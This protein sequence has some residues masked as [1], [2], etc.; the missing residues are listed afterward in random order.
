M[1]HVGIYIRAEVYPYVSVAVSVV[2]VSVN[3]GLS[4]FDKLTAY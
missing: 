1:V 2:S 4:V 3:H